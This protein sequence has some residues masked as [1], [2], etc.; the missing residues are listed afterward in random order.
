MNAIV[1]GEKQRAVHVGEFCRWR[2]VPR[3][4]VF[5]HH[6]A[7]GRA[8]ALPE[9]VTV[10]AVIGREEKRPIDVG[11]Q[12]HLAPIRAGLYLFDQFRRE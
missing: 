12:I 9:F 3:C 11:E 6:G 10:N 7:F 1:A 4:N 2:V 8:V 5:D